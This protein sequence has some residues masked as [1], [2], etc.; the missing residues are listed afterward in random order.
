MRVTARIFIGLAAAALVPGAASAAS[1]PARPV[2]I[3]SAALDCARV[4]AD[5]Q[6]GD[7]EKA[8]RSLETFI[9]S[10][11][12]CPRADSVFIAKHLA[13]IYASNPDTRERGR[14]YMLRMLDMAPDADL[15]DM[16]VG[17]EVDG[18]FGKVRREFDLM[19]PGRNKAAQPPSAAPRAEAKAS[20]PADPA[21]ASGER[22]LFRPQRGREPAFTA[23][24]PRNSVVTAPSAPA[25]AASGVRTAQAA[26][27]VEIVEAKREAPV[28][29]PQA[30]RAPVKPNHLPA[31]SAEAPSSVQASVS[32]VAEVDGPEWKG[33][34]KWV[35]GGVAIAVIGLTFYFSGSDDEPRAK[36]YVVHKN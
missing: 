14:Y 13:V 3:P 19:A 20:A 31:P 9:K 26:E 2:P 27:A 24:A 18:V 35:G 32:R 21:R 7:F 30:T 10:G 4:H 28:N 25:R 33:A 12:P 8:I 11:R 17:E 5:Y 1:A 34:A 29:A 16:F 36:N 15:L 23:P 6:N 22:P